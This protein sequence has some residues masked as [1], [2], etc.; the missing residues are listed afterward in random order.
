MDEAEQS[1]ELLPTVS[2]PSGVAN[3]CR[4]LSYAQEPL[5]LKVYTLPMVTVPTATPALFVAHTVTLE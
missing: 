3:N 1:T 5:E 4:P 2:V